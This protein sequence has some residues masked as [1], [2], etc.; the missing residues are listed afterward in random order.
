MIKL[1]AKFR[2]EKLHFHKK[3]T[4][5]LDSFSRSKLKLKQKIFRKILNEPK[6]T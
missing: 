5:R 6:R 2:E 4:A 1:T 3:F